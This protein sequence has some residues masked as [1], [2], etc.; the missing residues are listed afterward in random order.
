MNSIKE[1]VYECFTHG[2]SLTEV[3]K[4]FERLTG[5]LKS[6]SQSVEE[7]FEERRSYILKN[8]WNHTFDVDIS[9]YASPKNVYNS[10]EYHYNKM[11]ITKFIAQPLDKIGKDKTFYFLGKR[12]TKVKDVV[13]L[14]EHFGWTWEKKDASKADFFILG[15]N[16]D[17]A[18]VNST[19][20]RPIV[21]DDELRVQYHFLFNEEVTVEDINNDFVAVYLN[22]SDYDQLKLV[23]SMIQFLKDN[24]LSPE[25]KYRLIR[26]YVSVFSNVVFDLKNS[27]HVWLSDTVQRHCH[28]QHRYLVTNNFLGKDSGWVVDETSEYSGLAKVW[29]RATYH[30]NR[31]D[32]HRSKSISYLNCN[33]PRYSTTKEVS[34]IHASEGENEVYLMD[35]EENN[36]FSIVTKYN[37]KSISDYIT[38]SVS[39]HVPG[40][41][42]QLNIHLTD[43]ARTSGWYTKDNNIIKLWHSGISKN[44][45]L[46]SEEDLCREIP[47]DKIDEFKSLL[48]NIYT[49]LGSLIKESGGSFSILDSE[50][51]NFAIKIDSLVTN[52]KSLTSKMDLIK[53]NNRINSARQI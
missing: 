16:P 43:S 5:F 44:G 9:Q 29:G 23:V 7:F 34:H 39:T 2:S 10:L 41:L 3:L 24:N 51:L 13:K 50:L 37:F 27:E 14:A 38:R 22:S 20:S 31:W 45:V 1:L 48:D 36:S 26:S 32:N 35:L 18:Y 52:S 15:D 49:E 47:E 6:P 4:T 28:P 25:N 53:F 33:I 8:L 17:N 42:F 19:L 12:H 40:K 21:M 30:K 46:L 11:S